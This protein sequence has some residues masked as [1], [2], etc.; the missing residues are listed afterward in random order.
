MPENNAAE[1]QWS[2]RYRAYF[3]VIC[4]VAGILSYI[5]RQMLALLV[6]PIKKDLAI[7]D[8]QFSL[9][10]GF[11]FSF[12]YASMAFVLGRWIDRGTRYKIIAAGVAVWSLATL[13]TGMSNSF[14]QV[15]FARVAVGIGEAALAPTVA[16]MITDVFP[17]RQVG[18]AQAIFSISLVLGSGLAF[19]IGGSVGQFFGA[20]EFVDLPL[21]GTTKAWQAPFFV[22]GPPG[23]LLAVLML[24]SLREPERR[25]LLRDGEGVVR[26]ASL[27]QVLHYLA[28]NRRTTICLVLGFP[29]MSTTMY[30][31]IAWAPAHFMRVYGMSQAATGLAFGLILLTST[32]C[33][34]L[35]SGW[36]IDR[37][38][39]RGYEDA[40]VRVCVFGALGMLLPLALFSLLPSPAWSLAAIGLALFFCS[41][42]MPC[43][44]TSIQLVSPNQ[45]R[46]RINGLYLMWSV[47]M[48]GVVGPTLIAL[49]T[50][51]IFRSPKLVGH[52][53]GLVGSIAAVGAAVLLGTGLKHYR[54]TLARL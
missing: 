42:S 26:H 44:V 16:S 52:S 12:F 31:I 22:V 30:G 10:H 13:L 5:D 40:S 32:A 51:Y 4:L 17:R 53:L 46:G 36:L 6:D 8:T 48:S 21:V 54:V 25:H 29:C 50:D 28:D 27:R 34:V 11:A 33:G 41:F 45:M 1:G 23:L 19:L 9:L 47:T 18:R 14:W 43:G 15:F 49:I 39:A 3:L 20:G 2:A 35:L 38:Q 24:W 7:S 37:M